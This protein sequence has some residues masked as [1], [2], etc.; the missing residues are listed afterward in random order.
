MIMVNGNGEQVEDLS[1]VLR[2]VSENI[3]DEFATK[4]KEIFEDIKFVVVI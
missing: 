3:G 2:I 1:D 4:V